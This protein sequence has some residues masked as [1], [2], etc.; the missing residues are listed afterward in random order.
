VSC[1]V[2]RCVENAADL[3]VDAESPLLVETSICIG[4]ALGI[5]SFAT[6]DAE[7]DPCEKHSKVIGVFAAL[8]AAPEPVS[9][10][11]RRH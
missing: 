5:H 7:H 4:Y 3:P 11:D 2:C 9:P 8:C 10:F 6:G 1:P